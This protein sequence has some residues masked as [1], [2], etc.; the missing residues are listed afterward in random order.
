MNFNTFFVV[1]K[2]IT[3]KGVI[4]KK[5]KI[6]K[7]VFEQISGPGNLKFLSMLEHKNNQYIVVVDNIVQNDIFVY[8]LDYAEQE[9]INLNAFITVAEQ[10]Y[11]T[12]SMKY[13]LSFELSRFGLSSATSKIYRTFDLNT[14]QRLVGTPFKFD[15]STPVKIK[16][17]ISNEV[18]S[19]VLIKP[20][21]SMN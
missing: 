16:R 8:T 1:N 17:R 10:W 15:L 13:P 9:S 18:P 19:C 3:K 6:P 5:Q 11:N 7:I 2:V 12:N 4:I 20:K 14:V 21:N